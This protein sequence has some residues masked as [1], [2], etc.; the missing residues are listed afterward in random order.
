MGMIEQIFG[1]LFGSNRNVL[2]ETAEV[3]RINAEADAVR[4][5]SLQGAAL[6]QFGREFR[7][8]RRGWFDR[9]MDALNRVP[10]P[11][12]ALGT[13][14]LFVA[15]M[16]DPI[17]FAA[18]MAGIALVPEPLWWLL[19]AIVSFYFGARHQAKGQAFQR[20]LAAT[21]ATVPQVIRT[22][23]AVENIRQADDDDVA[24]TSDNPALAD[25][26][27]GKPPRPSPATM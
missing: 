6:D 19:A 16:I 27:A 2:A 11:A 4:W 26:Q 13:M 21:I 17:W 18:R 14:G 12:M 8:V 25:W 5:S 20:E 15:A 23:D 7:I 24:M 9:L 3:F 10:R 1:V 22:I